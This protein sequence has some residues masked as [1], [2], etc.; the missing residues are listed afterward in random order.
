MYGLPKAGILANHQLVFQLE[1]KVY[2]L[3]KH[4]PG[5]WKHK[6]IPVTFS[7]VVDNFGVKYVGKQHVGHLIQT[8]QGNYQVS[9]YWEVNRY[10][11]I[12]IKWNYHKHVVGLSIPG[13]IQASLHKF[14]HRQPTRK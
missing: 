11:G 7:L 4:T 10:C 2:V 12:T 6:W 1:T 13:Y 14:Q 8:I 9:T 3:C 5:L